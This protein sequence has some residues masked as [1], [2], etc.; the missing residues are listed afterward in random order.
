M[1]KALYYC[2]RH[3]EEKKKLYLPQPVGKIEFDKHVF[4]LK[5]C[6]FSDMVRGHKRW[7]V[8]ENRNN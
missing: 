5:T 3:I 7:Y 8:V 1:E 6:F 4:N 2:V